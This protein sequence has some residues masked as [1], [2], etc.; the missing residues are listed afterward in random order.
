MQTLSRGGNTIKLIEA[1]T[2]LKD[3]P[4]EEVTRIAGIPTVVPQQNADYL[5]PQAT[6]T[7]CRVLREVHTRSPDE[8]LDPTLFQVNNVR[9]EEPE[10][11]ENHYATTGTHLFPKVDVVDCTAQ[12]ELRMR[13]KVALELSMMNR[14]E[15]VN[16]AK[17]GGINFPTLRRIRVLVRKDA[18]GGATDG[19]PEHFV[20]SITVEATEQ[21]LAIPKAMPNASMASVVEILKASSPDPDRMIV[22]SLTE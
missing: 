21:D 4:P 6:L 17:S 15:F 5:S 10:P 18:A 2:E 13:E 19:A 1:S 11:G 9:I 20:S 8:L 14:E 16:E 22:A 3:R 12:L 7:V